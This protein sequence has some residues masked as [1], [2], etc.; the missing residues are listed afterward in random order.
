MGKLVVSGRASVIGSNPR[1]GKELTDANTLEFVHGMFSN[2]MCADYFDDDTLVALSISGGRLRF[3]ND[4]EAGTLRVSTAY[5]VPRDLE[6]EER[7][8]L[9]DETIG[10][11]SDGIGGGSFLCYKG[12]VLSTTL[13]MALQNS[14]QNP[15]LGELFV[16]AF[17]DVD[18]REVKVEYFDDGDSEEDLVADLQIGVKAGD[19]TAMVDLG[20]RYEEGLGVPKD[21]KL[22]FEHYE[23]A[24]NMDQPWGAVYLGQLLLNGEGC[25]KDEK[26]AFQCF[27][28]AA[29]SNVPL[30]LHF[31]GE[32]YTEGFGIAKDLVVAVKWYRKGAEFGDPGCLAELGDCLEYGR[33]VEKNL[34]EAMKCYQSALDAGFDPVLEAME[35]VRKELG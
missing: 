10:Q 4:K 12:Q 7:E 30:A 21:L 27:T 31:M 26:R 1:T 9:V 18:D 20:T 15:R 34:L 35:R 33:G 29:K 3:V 24:M 6:K 17:P 5:D 8:K 2:E 16:D 11:W 23:R 25:E 13:A 14:Q 19:A 28:I 22:A 32:C